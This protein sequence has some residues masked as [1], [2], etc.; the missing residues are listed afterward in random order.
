MN[1]DLISHQHTDHME[2]GSQFKVSSERPKKGELI[3]Q[4]IDNS[5]HGYTK[6]IDA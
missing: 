3:L 4:L 5:K 6:K 2:M 1:W